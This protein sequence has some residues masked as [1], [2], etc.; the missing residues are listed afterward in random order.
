MRDG[1]GRTPIRVTDLMVTPDFARLVAVGMYDMPPSQPGSTPQDGGTPAGSGQGQGA[2]ASANKSQSETRI[3]IYDLHT[4]QP[5]T[6]VSVS[7]SRATHASLGH[8]ICCV[9]ITY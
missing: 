2:G 5:E 9:R 6:C 4:K 7:V 1:W 3:I 8:E